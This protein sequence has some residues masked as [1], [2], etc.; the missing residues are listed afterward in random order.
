[1]TDTLLIS[2]AKIRQFT[3][4][5]QSVDTALIKN[6]I[7]TAQDYYLQAIIGTNLYNRLMSDVD[8]DTLAGYYLTILNDYIQD[9]LLYATYYETLESI[10]LRPRNNG[11]LKPNGGENSD[12][13]DRDIYQMKRQSIENKMAYYSERLTNYIIEEQDQFIELN[14]ADKLYE[15][16]P[17]YTNKYRNP[18]VLRQ[19][20]NGVNFAR[21]YGIQTY[22]SRYK[23]YPQ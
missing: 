7:R 22:D 20:Q 6:N 2:E 15:Q 1:M 4:I 16:W 5:N 13:V 10:Y 11:L 18:F 17:D 9:Y 21:Q 19:N 12:P 14:N 23:Q 8:N 3:D